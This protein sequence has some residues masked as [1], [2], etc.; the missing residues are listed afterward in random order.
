MLGEFLVSEEGRKEVKLNKASAT[1]KV[2]YYFYIDYLFDRVVRLFEYKNLPKTMPKKEI[3]LRLVSYGYCFVSNKPH[4][5]LYVYGGSLAN[6]TGVYYDEPLW[7]N[8]R[9]PNKSGTLICENDKDGVLINNNSTRNSLIRLIH[10]YAILLAHTEVTLVNQ[11]INL[12]SDVIPVCSNEN[13]A[14]AVRKYRSDIANGRQT[15]IVDSMM[16]GIQWEDGANKV[17]GLINETYQLRQDLMTNFYHDIG[18]KT[19]FNKQTI[20]LSSE[21]S[22]N[23]ELL[24]L[25]LDDLLNSRKDGIDRVNSKYGTNIEVDIAKCLRFDMEM[26]KLEFSS[27]LKNING[28]GGIDSEVFDK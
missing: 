8:Y 16:L 7:F 13:Q 20:Q 1:F 14:N 21:I 6:F 2:A 26:Q 25:N 22:A 23:D 5:D 3:E 12:R 10:N 11:L 4:K 27:N 9:C 24:N 19:A 17:S 28:I 15:P 18:V